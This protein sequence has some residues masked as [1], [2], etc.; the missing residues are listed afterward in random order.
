MTV[1]NSNTACSGVWMSKFVR[2]YS[3]HR[4][5][6]T[7]IAIQ[8][9]EYSNI[10]RIFVFFSSEYCWLDFPP[11]YFVANNS[12]RHTVHDRFEFKSSRLKYTYTKADAFEFKFRRHGVLSK[13]GFEFFRQI[14]RK[15]ESFKSHGTES[16]CF[17]IYIS[18]VCQTFGFEILSQHVSNTVLISVVNVWY[19]TDR[20]FADEYSRHETS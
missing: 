3:V 1:N 9:F 19:L 13:F 18:N 12:T 14:V 11:W 15:R 7:I 10:R 5:H 4:S 16:T 17:Y 2:T 20:I 8:T 6:G